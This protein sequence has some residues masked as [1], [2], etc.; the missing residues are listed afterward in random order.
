MPGLDQALLLL[1]SFTSFCQKC[2]EDLSE[3]IAELLQNRVPMREFPAYHC[4]SAEVARE[5]PL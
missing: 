3:E 5:K 2:E 4:I 1:L